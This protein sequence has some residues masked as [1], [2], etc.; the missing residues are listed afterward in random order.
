MSAVADYC[1]LLVAKVSID[2][3]EKLV[4]VVEK[5][6]GQVLRQYNSGGLR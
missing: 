4:A 2:V 6:R 5:A 1:K 3:T